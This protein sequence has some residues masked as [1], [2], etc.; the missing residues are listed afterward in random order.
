M[1]AVPPTEEKTVAYTFTLALVA[2][3]VVSM[4]DGTDTATYTVP[5]SKTAT[6]TL[7]MTITE[8]D[9]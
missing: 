8:V 2:A 6:G 9:V 4:T 1:A 3:D 5:A 7:V